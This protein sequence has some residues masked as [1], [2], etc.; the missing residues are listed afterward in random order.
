MDLTKSLS[1]F[2]DQSLRDQFNEKQAILN[3]YFKFSSK[4]FIDFGFSCQFSKDQDYI[5][6]LTELVNNPFISVSSF[7]SILNEVLHV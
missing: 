4:Y 3:W 7:I 1:S 2:K 5:E 6:L